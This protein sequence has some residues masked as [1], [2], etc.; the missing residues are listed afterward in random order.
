MPIDSPIVRRRSRSAPCW[1]GALM[2]L[3]VGGCCTPPRVI[4]PPAT[5]YF[6]KTDPIDVVLPAIN[7]NAAAVPSLW[8]QLTFAARLVDPRTKKVDVLSGTG[9]LLFRQPTS[10]RLVGEKDVAGPVFEL[11]SNPS[12]FWV[13]TRTGANDWDYWWGHQA[14]AGKPCCL[15]VPIRPDLVVGVLGVTAAG[16]DLL[17]QP[18]PVMRFDNAADAY[19]FDFVARRADRWVTVKEVA[20]DRQTKLAERVVLYDDAGRAVVSAALSNYAAV[21]DDGTPNPGGPRV[22]KHFD[23]LFPDTGSTM[24]FE[25]DDPTLTHA[26]GRATVPNDATFYRP[27]PDENNKVIQVDR[28]CADPAT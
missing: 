5:A 7:R 22:A 20:Y 27:D 10:L 3:A 1:R 15:D 21:S 28:A 8:T 6:G 2:A 14:N 18:V 24:S 13:K 23:L 25:F 19:V 16:V 26:A 11:G 17:R 12:E 9:T 4:T